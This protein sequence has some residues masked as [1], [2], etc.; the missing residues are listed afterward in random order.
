MGSIA[1]HIAISERIRQKYDLSKK[2]LVGCMLPDIEKFI[3]GRSQTHYFDKYEVKG[4]ILELPNLEKFIDS[5]M[6]RLEVK[7]E[8]AL[9][10][11]A[12]LIEDKIWFR[13]YIGERIH[14]VG[15]DKNNA[16]LHAYAKEDYKTVHTMEETKQI[17]YVD[18][19]LLNEPIMRE[20]S[21]NFDLVR[22][23]CYEYFNNDPQYRKIIDSQ[24]HDTKRVE[25]AE[26]YFCDYKDFQ[27]YQRLSIEEITKVFDTLN[28]V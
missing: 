17:M 11:L 15:Y 13:D 20:S 19:S 23:M 21:A 25:E 28:L 24:F 3:I 16:E 4:Q 27:D 5:N 26:C 9:G 14:I 22:N 8:I 1:M 12:H 18:Y 2:F 6:A 10:Y 7:D